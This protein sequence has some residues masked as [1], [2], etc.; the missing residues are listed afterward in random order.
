MIKKIILLIII[1]S[2]F[3]FSL[4]KEKKFIPPGTVQI[5]EKFFADET[6]IT[7][8]SWWEYE[9][10]TKT[11]FGKDSKEHLAVLPDTLVWNRQSGTNEGYV[12]TYYRHPAFRDY[13]V[14]GIS[15]EQALAYCK[16]RTEVVKQFLSVSHKKSYNFEY[17]LPTKS[18]WEFFSR[19]GFEVFGRKNSVELVKNTRDQKIYRM[20]YN[21]RCYINDSISQ[22]M[23]TSP[24]KGYTKN[25][26]GMYDM[27][28]N[29]SEMVTEKGI[30]KGGSW[31]HELEECRV[32]KD[33]PYTEP[34]AWLGFRC[35]CVVAD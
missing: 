20:H 21:A 5:S 16:W 6:E 4:K 7:N 3:S 9:F 14:V 29:V 17:R 2:G 24:I 26:F 12:K 33:I 34:S 27:I 1:S 25:I 23:F 11:K 31:K 22:Y 35:V 8:F 28:G 32:G 15:Y 30:S 19:N 18:E 13:P 10:W